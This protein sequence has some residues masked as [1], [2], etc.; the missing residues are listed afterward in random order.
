M[1]NC[2]N[3]DNYNH[4]KYN[5]PTFCEVIRQTCEETKKYYIE[6]L[7]DIR[8]EI[9]DLHTPYVTDAKYSDEETRKYNVDIL[10]DM[11]FEIVDKY[12]AK[13]K[14]SELCKE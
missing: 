10:M 9:K 11:I 2:L 8:E 4:E 12:I 14:E 5:C 3:C 7:E 6:Q 13:A 1:K